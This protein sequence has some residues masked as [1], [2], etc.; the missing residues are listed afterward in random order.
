MAMTAKDLIARKTEIL[1][2]K[3]NYVNVNLEGVGVWKFEIPTQGDYSD[4]EV[5]LDAH[6]NE[7]RNVDV[8]QV[9]WRCVEPNLKDAE[10]CKVYAEELGRKDA[11]PGAWILDAILKPGQITRVA[12]IFLEES[13]YTPKSAVAMTDAQVQELEKQAMAYEEYKGGE[14]IKNG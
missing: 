6:K 8:L 1:A 3:S 4:A 12:Q 14:E 13:G 5:Y 9:Y 10:L 2:R 7:A 11:T